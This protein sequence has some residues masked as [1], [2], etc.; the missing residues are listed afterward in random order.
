MILPFHLWSPR[1]SFLFLVAFCLGT[2]R[3]TFIFT[4][5]FSP[6]PVLSTVN[7]L[8]FLPPTTPTHL[9]LSLS[10][11]DSST[12]FYS[13]RSFL[14]FSVRL[15]PSK[16][17]CIPLR[18]RFRHSEPCLSPTICP[19]YLRRKSLRNVI[20]FL[21]WDTVLVLCVLPWSLLWTFSLKK[22]ALSRLMT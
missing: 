21:S 16:S 3:P 12:V 19:V 10:E 1:R 17:F 4:I 22:P 9:S 15:L 14:C 20:S 2:F 13:R 18:L 5:S 11:R 8:F 6:F 7:V